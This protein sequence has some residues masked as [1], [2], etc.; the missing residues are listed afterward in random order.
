[1]FLILLLAGG[2]VAYLRY[3]R[4]KKDEELDRQLQ[5]DDRDSEDV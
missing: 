3:Q 4:K 2:A 1:V 5:R